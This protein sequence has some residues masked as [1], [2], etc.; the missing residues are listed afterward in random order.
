[1]FNSIYDSV[2]RFRGGEVQADDITG[3]IIKIK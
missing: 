1:L 3:L 2:L